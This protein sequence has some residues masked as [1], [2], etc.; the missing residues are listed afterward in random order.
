MPAPGKPYSSYRL[1]P[2]IEPALS[3]SAMTLP[4]SRTRS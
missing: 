2:I 1:M 3:L 4:R